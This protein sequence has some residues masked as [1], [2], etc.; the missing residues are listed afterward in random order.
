MSN[1]ISSNCSAIPSVS[2][3]QLLTNHGDLCPGTFLWLLQF[4][5]LETPELISKQV[6]FCRH[7]G[8]EWRAASDT[9][10]FKGV[11]PIFRIF[12]WCETKRANNASKIVWV[13]GLRILIIKRVGWTK[14][15]D[16]PTPTSPEHQLTSTS[17]IIQDGTQT[18]SLLQILQEQGA[19]DFFVTGVSGQRRGLEV[20]VAR[21]SKNMI[22]AEVMTILRFARCSKTWKQINTDSAIFI[23]VS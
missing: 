4:P 17:E 9:L 22:L 23:A 8:V 5:T 13:V 6:T 1:C 15:S 7:F 11:T 2:L 14:D 21:S 3:P 12:R 18:S 16:R 19:F 20:W 10:A